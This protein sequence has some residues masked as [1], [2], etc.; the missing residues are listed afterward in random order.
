MKPEIHWLGHASFWLRVGGL[1]VYIDPWK[2]QQSREADIILVTHGHRDHLSVVDIAKIATPATE[3]VVPANC[4]E[5]LSGIVHYVEPGQVIT[6]RGL[7]VEAVPSY[8]SN[9][10]NHPQSAG[11]VGYVVT[12]GEQRIYHAGDTD[13]I[14]EMSDIRCDVAL[15]PIGGTYTMDAEEAARALALIKPERAVPM[16]WGDIVGGQADAERFRSLA[17]AGV[18]VEILPIEA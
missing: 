11:N 13:L 16:H 7:T 6:V 2:L 3:T 12:D 5:R 15:L 14:P 18:A 17:P 9:K 1:T 10:P 4:K 8:N